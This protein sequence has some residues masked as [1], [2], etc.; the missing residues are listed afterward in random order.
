MLDSGGNS[1]CG[2]GL[3]LGDLRPLLQSRFPKSKVEL[4]A[5]SAILTDLPSWLGVPKKSGGISSGDM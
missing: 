3:L 1:F 5:G 2:L 4:T